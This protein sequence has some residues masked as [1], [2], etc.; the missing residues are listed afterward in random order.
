M[1][2]KLNKTSGNLLDFGCGNGVHSKY[3]QDVTGGGY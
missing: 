3:F 2:Y 1:K